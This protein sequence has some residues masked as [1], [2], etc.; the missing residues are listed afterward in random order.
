MTRDQPRFWQSRRGCQTWVEGLPQELRHGLNST[1]AIARRDPPH[2]ACVPA[3]QAHRAP[4][5]WG[6]AGRVCRTM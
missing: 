5:R 1:F 6:A 3:D 4:H 2:P